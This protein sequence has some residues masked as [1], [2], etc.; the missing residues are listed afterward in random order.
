MHT[1][2]S[3]RLLALLA[4]S[5]I[6]VSLT[7]SPAHAY[8]TRLHIAYANELRE[9]LILSGDGSI[10]LIGSDFAVQLPAEVPVGCV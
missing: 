6:W 7:A 1:S 9:A 5:T 3:G 4:L 2:S 8:S 10:Q